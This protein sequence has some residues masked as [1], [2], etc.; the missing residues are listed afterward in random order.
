MNLSVPEPR[1]PA[2]ERSNG[3][4][5]ASFMARMM[6]A[7]GVSGNET[8]ADPTH[9]RVPTREGELVVG[10]RFHLRPSSDFDVCTSVGGQ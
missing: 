3:E 8:Q 5:S 2:R 10:L 1:A 6:S 4:A 7:M 9:H